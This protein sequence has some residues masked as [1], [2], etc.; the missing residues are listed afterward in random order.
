M[1]FK[2]HHTSYIRL[3]IFN[4]IFFFYSYLILFIF[5]S[6]FC[7]VTFFTFL[8]VENN[9]IIDRLVNSATPHVELHYSQIYQNSILDLR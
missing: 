6:T 5:F 2:R 7:H 8:Y 4:S 3:S 9:K 1:D